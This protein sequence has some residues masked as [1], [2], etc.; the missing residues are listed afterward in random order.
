M[1][2]DCISCGYEGP[3]RPADIDSKIN[4]DVEVCPVCNGTD[5]NV[6]V[7]DKPVSVYQSITNNDEQH[8]K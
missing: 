6:Y 5:F 3:A 4:S 7:E 8:G 2:I 1:I